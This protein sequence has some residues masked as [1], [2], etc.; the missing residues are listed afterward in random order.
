MTATATETVDRVRF[1]RTAEVQGREG[2][3][4]ILRRGKLNTRVILTSELEGEGELVS[5]AALVNERELDSEV[6][7][8]SKSKR[9][10]RFLRK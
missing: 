7:D 1:R 8:P 2:T 10:Q 9:K 5:T 4:F 3:F 6:V